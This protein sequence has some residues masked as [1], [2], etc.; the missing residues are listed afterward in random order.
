MTVI[1][2]NVLVQRAENQPFYK[3]H[4]RLFSSN[5]VTPNAKKYIITTAA[6]DNVIKPANLPTL[7]AV[8]RTM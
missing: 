5:A 3:P 4:P 2:R 8:R 6:I 7:V 1:S